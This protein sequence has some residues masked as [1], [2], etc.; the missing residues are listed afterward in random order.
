MGRFDEYVKGEATNEFP[1][2]YVV[3]DIET[4]GLDPVNDH[5][6]EISALRYRADRKVDEFVTLVDPGVPVSDFITKLTGITDDMLNGAPKA[7]EAASAF[8]DFIGDD[9]LVGYNVTFDLAFLN[10]VVSTYLLKNIFNKY[11]DVMQ[12]AMDKLSF[13]G[14]AKQIVVARYFGLDTEGS[15][16]ALNDSEICNGCYQKL[17]ELS[18]PMYNMPV[19]QLIL[20]ATDDAATRRPFYGKKFIFKGV[21]YK[22][23]LKNLEHVVKALGGIISYEDTDNVDIVVVG[24]AD[25]SVLEREDFLRLVELKEAGA[26]FALMKDFNFVKGLITRGFV[27]VL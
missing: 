16:R 8:M 26:R 13:L 11:I 2:D 23:Y 18:V 24:T 7:A 20:A 27:Q 10:E 5:V 15:H 3:I 9:I 6:I 4:T 19:R 12:L 21:P 17:K 25:K 14:R 22:W 1:A